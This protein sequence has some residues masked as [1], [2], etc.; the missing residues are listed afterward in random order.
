MS[1]KS[2]VEQAT[3]RLAAERGEPAAV[4]D[5]TP[6]EPVQGDPEGVESNVGTDDGTDT[7]EDQ[8]TE[9]DQ[10]EEGDDLDEPE[11]SGDEKYAE[12]ESKYKALE[13]EFSR[14][15]ANRKAIEQNLEEASVAAT[16]RAHEIESQYAQ[17]QQYAEYFAALPMQ[18]VQTLQQQLQQPNL[19]P[20]QFQSLYQQLNQA[21][22]MAQQFQGALNQIKESSEKAK[23]E[24]RRREAELTMSRIKARIPGWNQERATELYNLAQEVGYSDQEARELTDFRTI[25]LMN[26]VLEAR[27]AKQTVKETG[28]KRKPQPP[29]SRGATQPRSSNGQFAKAERDFKEARPGTKGAFA[30]LKEQQ[31]RR[32]REGK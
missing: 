15:T 21:Q 5:D 18:Q 28:T 8:V 20:E 19:Q 27:K 17:A 31:L 10:P 14:V 7:P 6:E 25:S 22:A 4:H 30:Q 24:Q 11:D 1:E 2:F 26:E 23:Q 3:E 32:E 29:T 9:E 12:L 13:A 16:Q